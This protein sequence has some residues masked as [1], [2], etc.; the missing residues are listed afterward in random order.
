MKFFCTYCDRGY[1]ARMRCLHESLQAQGEPFR[2][3]VLCFDAD[4]EAV[5]RAAEDTSLVA[6]SLPEL[7]SADPAYANVRA[8]RSRVEFFFTSTPVLVHHCLQREP[9][10]GDMTYLDAD[11]FFFEPASRVFAEQGNASVGIVPHRFPDRK[12]VV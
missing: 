4:T 1:A 12:S 9:S 2:L 6:V 11:L 8:Q 7:L 10:A 3:F 5:V